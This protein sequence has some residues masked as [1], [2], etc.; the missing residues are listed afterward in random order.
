[1][2]QLVNILPWITSFI[3]GWS[4]INGVLHDI[5]VLIAERGKKYDRNLL[6]LL[7]DGHILIT[8]G[9]I[10]LLCHS[11]IASGQHFAFFIAMACCASLLVYCAMIWPFLKSVVTTFISFAGLL[12]LVTVY[13]HIN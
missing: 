8:C 5:F 4:L 10:L 7:M 9:I 6:R 12:S 11:S 1:M 3:G 13:F 2:Q